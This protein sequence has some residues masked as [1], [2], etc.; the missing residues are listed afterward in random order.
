MSIN[1][2]PRTQRVATAS[3]KYGVGKSTLFRWIKEGKLT[4]VRPS[5][6]ITL[7]K[8]DELEKLFNSSDEVKL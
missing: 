2:M 6:R 7:L 8:T 1:D 3:L 4:A 5:P